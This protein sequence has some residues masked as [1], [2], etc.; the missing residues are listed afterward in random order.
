MK[1]T[2]YICD[3]CGKEITSEE[4]YSVFYGQTNSESNVTKTQTLFED[5]CDDCMENLK[6][7]FQSGN[8]VKKMPVQSKGKP[9]AEP[10]KRQPFDEGKA[11]ALRNAGWSLE[12]IA[13]EMKCTPSTVSYH[14][15]KL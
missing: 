11:R 3:S 1:K 15:M 8:L 9:Q 10:K 2:M 14:L 4:W 7:M 12:K 13:E 6:A 5:I